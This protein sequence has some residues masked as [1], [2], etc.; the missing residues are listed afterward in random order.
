MQRQLIDGQ[1]IECHRGER[2]LPVR[3]Q[4]QRETGRA[5]RM[6]TEELIERVVF[7]MQLKVI[8]KCERDFDVDLLTARGRRRTRIEIGQGVDEHR[9]DVEFSRVKREMK[10]VECS[11]VEQ[12]RVRQLDRAVER[13]VVIRTDQLFALIVRCRV[14]FTGHM[15]ENITRLCRHHGYRDNHEKQNKLMDARSHVV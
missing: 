7:E 11:A 5:V 2:D 8:L 3:C 4:L 12:R 6:F 14:T 9:R 13:R 1:L 10:A 15:L